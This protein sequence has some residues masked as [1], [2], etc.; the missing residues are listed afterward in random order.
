MHGPQPRV[1]VPPGRANS[2][3]RSPARPHTHLSRPIAGRCRQNLTGVS[4]FRTRLL[5]H[6]LTDCHVH[7][8]SNIA[9]QNLRE[10]CDDSLPHAP[11]RVL[12]RHSP[13]RL[14]KVKSERERRRARARRGCTSRGATQHQD[15]RCG[16][17]IRPVPD[18]ESPEVFAAVP[19]PRPHGRARRAHK[20]SEGPRAFLRRPTAYK[21]HWWLQQRLS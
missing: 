15:D 6:Q 18:M 19:P 21:L 2:S 11:V 14:Q 4:G 10:Y 3:P 9:F 7:R 13:S 8:G 20:T 16:V 5:C 17:S 12:M 1:P